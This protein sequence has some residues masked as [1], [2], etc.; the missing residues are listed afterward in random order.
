MMQKLCEFVYM[1]VCALY[2]WCDSDGGDKSKK[3]R[4]GIRESR[5]CVGSEDRQKKGI[6]LLVLGVHV[7]VLLS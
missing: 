1:C 4:I 6:H 5:W 3:A 7:C 2:G